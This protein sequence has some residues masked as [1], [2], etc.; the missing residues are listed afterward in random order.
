VFT[1]QTDPNGKLTKQ[2]YDQFG[3]LHKSIDAANNATTFTYLKD[4]LTSITDANNNVTGYEYDSLKRLDTTT[5]PDSTTETYTYTADGMLSWKTDRKNKQIRYGYDHLKRLTQKLYGVTSPSITYTYVGQKLTSIFDTY[6][7]PTEVHSFTYDTSYRVASNTQNYTR[8]TVSYTHDAADRVA[9]YT[10]TSGPSASYTYYDDGSLKDITSSLISGQ[11]QYAYTLNGQY[12]TIT[13][14]NSQYRDYTYDDQGRLTQVANI[15][16]TPGNLATYAYGYDVDNY[17]SNPTMLGQRSSLTATVPAQSFSSSVSNYYYDSNYQLTQTGYPNVAPYSAEVDSWTYDNIGN[18]LTN[19]VNGN[20]ANYSYYKNGSNQLNGQRLQSDGTKT[21]TYDSN[22]SMTGDGTYTHTWDYENRL[23]AISGGGLTASYKYDYLGRRTSKTVGGS[24]TTYLY[25]GQ[26]LINESGATAADY[27]FGPGIDEPLAMVRSSTPYYFDVD[28]L[29]S[30]TLVN[31]ATGTV[32]DNYVLDAWGNS[33]AQTVNVANPFTYTARESADAGLMYY[34]ARYYNPG[35]GRFVSEDPINDAAWARTRP[36][37]LSEYQLRQFYVR[38]RFNDGVA[39]L[40]G[41]SLE[42]PYSYA[43]NN[44]ADF[45]D[46]YGLSASQTEPTGKPHLPPGFD[47]CLQKCASL[48]NQC[49]ERCGVRLNCFIFTC[50]CYP[51]VIKTKQGKITVHA[52]PHC[53]CDYT[54]A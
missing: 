4:L 2:G 50:E 54:S 48:Y 21:Y 11:F 47:D 23:T 17:T 26:N 12:G 36:V 10:V 33:K 22:G 45:T 28:G 37:L 49:V 24:T 38:I 32:Q 41:Q 43:Q 34:R 53:S 8:G 15:H 29:G 25:D 42:M 51:S 13:F 6:A 7:S 40:A 35:I 30:A 20:T 9:G 16:P 18:R 39:P 44:P 3:R 14:P 1:R 5:F 46:P 31:N 19:T 27:V 52:V